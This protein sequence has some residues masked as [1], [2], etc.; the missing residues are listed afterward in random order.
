MHHRAHR[1]PDEVRVPLKHRLEGDS[2]RL[3]LLLGTSVFEIHDGRRRI[4]VSEPHVDFGCLTLLVQD[5]A[6]GLQ[7]TLPGGTWADIPPREGHVVVNFGKLFSLWTGCRIVACEH[8]VLSPNCERFSIPF[9]YEPRLDYEIAPLPHAGAVP[10]AP[11][12]YGDY[13]W[14]S[15]PRL[16]RLFG[17]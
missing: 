5:E 16:R 14:S 12:V 2:F 1:R 9:F 17:N 3:T 13:V 15:L 8:R 10:F 6:P 11:F 7:V 4:I